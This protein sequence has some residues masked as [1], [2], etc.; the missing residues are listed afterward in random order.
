MAHQPRHTAISHFIATHC[1][2]LQHTA[3]HCNT[4]QLTAT[5]GNT[6]QHTCVCH[7][8]GVR[9][10]A[11]IASHD[12]TMT[13]PSSIACWRQGQP[14]KLLFDSRQ[15]IFFQVI[16]FQSDFLQSQLRTYLTKKMRKLGAVKEA[17]LRL[18]PKY[19]IFF[20]RRHSPVSLLDFTV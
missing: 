2:T 11:S 16:S 13:F 10:G 14:K 12:D 18:P 6:L 9:E 4:L 20:L 1:N 17:A 7:R 15:N 8:H 19:N 3:T 5:H